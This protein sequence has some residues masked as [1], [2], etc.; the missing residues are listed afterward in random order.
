M[1]VF[2]LEEELQLLADDLLDDAVDLAVGEL[3]LGLA[4]EAGLGDLDGD[5]GD[6]ALADVVAGD[7]RDPSP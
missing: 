3:G 5:D 4:L 2:G 1:L 6:E 7:G